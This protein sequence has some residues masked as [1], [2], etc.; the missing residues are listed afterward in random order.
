[1][2]KAATTC[3]RCAAALSPGAAKCPRCALDL[4][5]ANAASAAAGSTVIGDEL[6]TGDFNALEPNATMVDDGEEPQTA[7]SDL[8]DTGEN[9]AHGRGAG[10]DEEVD[11]DERGVPGL[12]QPGSDV[13]T[14]KRV[15][16]EAVEAARAMPGSSTMHS[17]P[18]VED[19]KGRG[20]PLPPP[21]Q[22]A[23][24]TITG[25]RPLTVPRKAVTSNPAA[26][27]AAEVSPRPKKSP[28]INEGGT[29]PALP[30]V[31]VSPHALQTDDSIAAT[32]RNG[33]PELRAD[34]APVRAAAPARASAAHGVVHVEPLQKM[35]VPP[36]PVHRPQTNTGRVVDSLLNAQLGEYI[37]AERIGVGGMGIVYRAKQPMIGTNVAIKVLR[38]DVLADPRD[39]ERLLHEAKVV[40]QIKHRGIISI[41]GAGQ[42]P[43]NRQYLVMEYLEGE[44][45]EKRLEREGQLK[46]EV[47]V[48]ILDEVLAA[49][50]AAHDA[51]IVHRDLKP[52]NVFLV[53]QSD[54]RPWVKLLDFGLARRNTNDVSRIAGTPDYIS[55]EHARG[56]PAGPPTDIY[57]V[58]ILA[59]HLLTGQ[60]PFKGNSP[61]EVMEK[62]V[63]SPPPDPLSINPNIPPVLSGFALKL[64]EKDPARRPDAKQARKDLKAAFK[65]LN[66]SSHMHLE[67]VKSP[68]QMVPDR[69]LVGTIGVSEAEV[70]PRLK[71]LARRADR[72]KW[73]RLLV[74]HW[75]WVA[76]VVAIVWVL[77]VAIYLIATPAPS[78]TMPQALPIKPK[79]E[80]HGPP[81]PPR[82]LGQIPG[83]DTPARAE[84]KKAPVEEVKAA[85]PEEKPEEKKTEPPPSEELAVPT[86]AKTADEKPPE[87][88]PASNPADQHKA[89]TTAVE[90]R[91]KFKKRMND[92]I[93]AEEARMEG[94]AGT[95]Y[96]PAFENLRRQLNSDDS[97]TE[98]EIMDR[99]YELH[100]KVKRAT[101]Q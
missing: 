88:K 65:D 84:E 46:P 98:K 6:S 8:P 28:L 10:E 67:P 23:R 43:D 96:K 82:P 31:M 16:L 49:L 45:L 62:H 1:M 32:P 20:R 90:D 18:P 79:P 70:D 24:R 86:E 3:P 37:I 54:G 11:T 51:G 57:A 13:I 7:A 50:G 92:S 36:P 71:D 9:P 100:E 47:V 19:S 44:T 34:P 91:E 41:F 26:R 29:L 5:A 72:A 81:G 80:Q 68:S 27:A 95:E 85:P 87:E 60:L 69:A 15:A 76:G 42:L 21:S 101:L 14:D 64:L 40:N 94:S 73:S 4:A 77:G 53:K 55:P 2:T 59:F 52:A 97:L 74:Q 25:E 66:F 56:R 78:A 93:D 58:G 22:G 99:F 61:M 83:A 12:L 63:H 33:Q 39:V 35:E 17:A 89:K 48:P 75:P 38:P 30:P